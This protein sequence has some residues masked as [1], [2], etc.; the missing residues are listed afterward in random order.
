MA[1]LEIKNLTVSFD[2]STGPFKAV[3]GIDISVDKGEVLAIVGESGSGKSVGMLAVMGL[4][5]K[6]ATVTADSMTFDGQ[7][8]KGMSDKERRKIIGRDI[9][10]IFQEPV[11]SLN[12][13]FT[14]GYQLEEVLKRHMGLK[15][16]AS[17]ARAIELL[18]LVGI[19]DAAERLSSFP[20]QMSGGQCQR[21]MIAI[22]IACNP[23]LLIA[24]EP[25]TAL[26][27]TIQKQILDLLMRLQ[28]EHGM[29]L[30]MITHDMGVVAETADRVIVQYK[31]HKMEDAD[32]LSL[33][34]APKHPYTRALLSALPENATGDRLPTV[35]DFVFANNAAGEA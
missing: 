10:M 28:V 13:C 5:P 15:G 21:V 8:L 7:D 34:S 35:S 20:H 16:S 17:R 11:A 14:V 22:A 3:D 6:T 18:E 25:T 24:D 33:F 2:T 23:K 1:L 27:V 31:G 32:V 26:D 12:P 19:R 29:G 9:S 30:I 4:L